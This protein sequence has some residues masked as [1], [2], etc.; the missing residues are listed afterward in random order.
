MVYGVHLHTSQL[1]ELGVAPPV[2]IAVGSHSHASA[3]CSYVII[4]LHHPRL[5]EIITVS[6]SFVLLDCTLSWF[7][8]SG[9]GVASITWQFSQVLFILTPHFLVGNVGDTMSATCRCDTMS[10]TCC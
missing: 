5:L 2:I 4:T 6:V 9:G 1:H 8:A 3:S 7:I 10:A